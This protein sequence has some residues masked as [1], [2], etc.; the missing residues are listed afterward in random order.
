MLSKSDYQTD[1][2]SFSKMY[3]IGGFFQWEKEIHLVMV[4]LMQ[5]LKVITILRMTLRCKQIQ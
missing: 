1:A 5:P 4:I 3:G 2:D